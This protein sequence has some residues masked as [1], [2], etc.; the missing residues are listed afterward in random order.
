MNPTAPSRALIAAILDANAP[1]V[2]RER[3]REWLGQLGLSEAD[4][5]ATL[6]YGA[7]RLLVYRTLVHARV[8]DVVRQW[9]PLTAQHIGP[10]TLAEDVAT[11]FAEQRGVSTPYLR[12]VPREFVAFSSP[13][14]AQDPAR[15][16]WLGELARFELL[17]LDVR[18]DPRPHALARD[19]PPRLD[20]PIEHNPTLRI[21]RF[22]WTVDELRGFEDAP[23]RQPVNLVAVRRKDQRTHHARVSDLELAL[24]EELLPGKVLHVALLGAASR[25]AVSLDDAFL[26][27]AATFLQRMG[28]LDVLIGPPPIPS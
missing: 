18:N 5:D 9:V 2:L 17:R 27:Q 3:P 25:L 12:D 6:R 28:E 8:I 16:P 4:V 24:L 14:W 13:R 1:E 19:L 15:V 11:F 7:E 23:S 22:S 26:A 20:A 21:E 10:R